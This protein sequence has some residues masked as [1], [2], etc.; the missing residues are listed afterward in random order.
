MQT[1]DK[2]Y[3]LYVINHSA[4]VEDV[5][6]ILTTAE[7][8]NYRV[9]DIIMDQ[10]RRIRARDNVLRLNATLDAKQIVV[11]EIWQN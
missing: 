3:V 2:G 8:G 5:E 7:N 10:E 6:I 1:N 11:W 4:T 9:R